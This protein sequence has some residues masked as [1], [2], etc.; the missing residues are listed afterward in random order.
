MPLSMLLWAA[1]LPYVQAPSIE[2]ISQLSLNNIWNVP[3]GLIPRALLN[4]AILMV[5]VPTLTVVVSLAF[6]WVVMRSDIAFRGMYDF[7]A[8][9]PHAVPSIIFSVAAWLLVVRLHQRAAHLRHAVGL[10]H[11]LRHCAD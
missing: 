9:L 2:A 1:G 3:E 11:R 8:F 5:V 10:D 7:F 4:T 6:S